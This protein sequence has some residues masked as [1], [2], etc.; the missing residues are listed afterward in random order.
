MAVPVMFALASISA[1]SP[2]KITMFTTVN[3]QF[4]DQSIAK[5]FN[6]IFKAK[7]FSGTVFVFKVTRGSVPARTP[8]E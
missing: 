2:R 6:L 4:Q 8:S 3:K 1:S 5:I 7:S